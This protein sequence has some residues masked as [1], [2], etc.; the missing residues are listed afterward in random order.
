MSGDG[1]LGIWLRCTRA[2]NQ[3]LAGLLAALPASAAAVVLLAAYRSG[4]PDCLFHRLTGWHCP[5]C[6]GTRMV[7]ALLK[8]DFL[9][10][11]RFNPLLFSAGAVLAAAAVWLIVRSLRREWRP[12]CIPDGRGWLAIPAALLLFLVI[13]NTPWYGM[14]FF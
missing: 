13:R 2:G 9:A 12:L 8:G 5:G 11:M 1:R 6:G 14:V 3:T 4:L 7:Q 10:A